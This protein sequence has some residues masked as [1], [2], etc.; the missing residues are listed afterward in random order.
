M[1]KII[2]LLFLFVHYQIW[3]EEQIYATIAHNNCNI[4]A[5]Y[6]TESGQYCVEI[7]NNTYNTK[8]KTDWMYSRPSPNGYWLN[9]KLFRMDFGS[10]LAPNRYTYIYSKDLNILSRRYDLAMVVD[11]NNS[12]ILCAEFEY[13]IYNIFHPEFYLTID[14]PNDHIGGLLWFG[15]GENTFFDDKKLILEYYDENW[16]VK[17]KEYNL[18]NKKLY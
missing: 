3:S 10:A 5:Y 17:I 18:E 14:K 12:L 4:T 13:T 16:K 15:T 9:D 7:I 1:R 2:I 11:L 6:E 8:I